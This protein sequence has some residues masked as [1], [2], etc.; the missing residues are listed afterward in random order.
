VDFA[1]KF[2]VEWFKAA[3]SGAE[4]SRRVPAGRPVEGDLSAQ[5]LGSRAVEVLER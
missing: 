5:Q 2:V 3:R 1:R 4:H